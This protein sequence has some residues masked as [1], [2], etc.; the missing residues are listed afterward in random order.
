MFELPRFSIKLFGLHDEIG[1]SFSLDLKFFFFYSAPPLPLESFNI[2]RQRRGGRGL[3]D[4]AHSCLLCFMVQQRWH[5]GAEWHL[6]SLYC[7]VSSVRG[8]GP[9]VQSLSSWLG[10]PI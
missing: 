4:P 9:K 1:H 10:V 5:Y 8:G 2:Y 3:S 6:L 7:H